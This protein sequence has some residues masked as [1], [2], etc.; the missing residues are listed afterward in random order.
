MREYE[1]YAQ[2]YEVEGNVL[3]AICICDFDPDTFE[4]LVYDSSAEGETSP[5]REVPKVLCAKA[6]SKATRNAERPRDPRPPSPGPDD[7]NSEYGDS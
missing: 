1:S 4:N 7:G 5:D 3:R 2:L 6:K